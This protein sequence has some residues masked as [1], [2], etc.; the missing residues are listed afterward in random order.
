LAWSLP[1]HTLVDRAATA[2]GLAMRD[3]PPPAHL[4]PEQVR[5]EPAPEPSGPLL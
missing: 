3:V 4:K 1:R 2:E 5:W